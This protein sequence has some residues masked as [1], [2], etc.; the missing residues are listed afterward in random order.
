MLMVATR[1]K[2]VVL[3]AALAVGCGG[4]GD[5]DSPGGGAGF[6]AD[7]DGKAWAAE[8][9]GVTARAGGVPG[10]IV[11]T[12]S[13][14][15]GS[16][17]TSLSLSLGLITG[18]GT[19]A[20]GVGPTVYGGNGSVG[21][22][23]LGTGAA[24]VWTTALD[25]LS[26]SVTITTLGPRLVGTFA[27]TGTADKRNALGGMRAV[28]NGRIDLPLQGTL[29]PVR[30]NA[31][32]KVSV[33]TSS[34]D[35]GVSLMLVGVTTPGSYPLSNV[36]PLRTITVGRNGGDAN[37]CC[38]GL[39]AGGDV[40]TIEITSLSPTRVK[41]TFTGTLQPQPGKAATTPIAVTAGSF[42]VG[43]E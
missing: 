39:N 12:G 36:A 14:L 13:Q 19:Y 30:E 41:G 8:P 26:G 10:G 18:P 20:L 35:I 21:E 23:P 43:I 17:S 15:T 28:T 4:G 22:A 33:D 29:V 16:T 3:A 40:G 42:D 37:H 25:G 9:I 31:G 7:I 38:W 34:A 27:F 5:G 32:S 24:N 1:S 6:T 11:V 2:F